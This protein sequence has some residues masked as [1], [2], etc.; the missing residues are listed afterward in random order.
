MFTDPLGVIR[1]TAPVKGELVVVD[2]RLF[3]GPESPPSVGESAKGYLQ[4]VRR[5][6]VKLYATDELS[7]QGRFLVEQRAFGK[8]VSAVAPYDTRG[9]LRPTGSASNTT[10]RSPLPAPIRGCRAVGEERRTTSPSGVAA[11]P[12]PACPTRSRAA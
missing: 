3:V 7:Y 12:T 10:P 9:S 8:G 6:Y 5:W 1:R 11:S 2:M 4:I